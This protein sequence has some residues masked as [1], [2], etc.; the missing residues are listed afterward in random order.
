MV[1]EQSYFKY[2]SPLGI[3]TVMFTKRGIHRISFNNNAKNN[4]ISKDIYIRECDY[5][6]YKYIFGEL[7]K[8]FTGKLEKFEVPVVLEGTDFQ[9]SVWYELMKIPY[10]QSSTYGEIARAIGSPNAAR[11][12]GN[13]NNK[14]KLPII[15]PCH[16]VIGASGNLTGY[17]GG[18]DR[19][20]WLIYH[21]EKY[22]KGV[23][24]G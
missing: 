3:L 2:P 1:M 7:N 18:L 17:A 15:I 10:G 24:Y 13:A 9:K 4:N 8:Y 20:K 21:E 12:V 6:I 11:A 22:R 14:N 16:R 5:S 19:K 23:V